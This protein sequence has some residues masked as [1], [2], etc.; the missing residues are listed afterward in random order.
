MGKATK[1]AALRWHCLW[2][3]R[4]LAN[5]K[6]FGGVGYVKPGGHV[7]DAFKQTNYWKKKARKNQFI[8]VYMNEV[9]SLGRNSLQKYKSKL[10]CPSAW[11]LRSHDWLAAAHFP[12]A[13]S[14]D[15][16]RFFVLCVEMFVSQRPATLQTWDSM[17]TRTILSNASIMSENVELVLH[18]V[19]TR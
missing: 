3:K 16:Q 5:I 8:S 1:T 4:T 17:A 9:A 19:Q 11:T 15:Y 2:W 12:K 10:Y 7:E 6:K 18:T 13:L 14:P